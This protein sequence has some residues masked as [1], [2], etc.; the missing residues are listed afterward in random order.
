MKISIKN[1]I[2]PFFIAIILSQAYSTVYLIGPVYLLTGLHIPG[3][4][5]ILLIAASFFLLRSKVDQKQMLTKIMFTVIFC[6]IFLLLNGLTF[7]ETWG[8]ASLKSSIRI[9]LLVLALY[10]SFLY[11]PTKK[12]VDQILKFHITITSTL[13]ILSMSFIFLMGID[14]F[15]DWGDAFMDQVTGRDEILWNM[16]V[17]TVT[18]DLF[19]RLTHPGLN[20][21][22]MAYSNLLGLIFIFYLKNTHF[23]GYYKKLIYIFLSIILTI[24]VLV[25]FAR[26]AYLVL[27]LISCYRLFFLNVS[28]QKKFFFVIVIL[29]MVIMINTFFPVIIERFLEPIYTLLQIDNNTVIPTSD[30]FSS[31][32]HSLG[33]ITANPLGIS[34]EYY[35]LSLGGMSGEHNLV[36]ST[37]I[38]HGIFVSF[39]IFYIY[40]YSLVKLL[41]A[42][43]GRLIYKDL[44]NELM[45]LVSVALM[46]LPAIIMYT[47]IMCLVIMIFNMNNSDFKRLN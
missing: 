30:R 36:L 8:V 3:M 34:S 19:P 39:I 29:F 43:D 24:G 37:A 9:I 35:A 32:P 16:E 5:F 41:K 22:N 27:F 47:I 46:F 26:Q 33:I 13:L 10:L 17:E 44:L 6:G 21:I 40:F 12:G 23:S 38:I 7:H 25:T 2:L 45:I 18:G 28:I 31:T 42:N 14:G 4:I 20:T 1:T 11:F 15:L